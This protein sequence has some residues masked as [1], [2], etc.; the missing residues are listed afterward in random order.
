VRLLQV[1]RDGRDAALRG[2]FADHTAAPGW[3]HEDSAPGMSFLESG[4]CV[5][6]ILDDDGRIAGECG[7][8]STPG[9]DGAVEIGYGLAPAS[10]GHGLGTS[11]VGALL[12]WLDR[13]ADVRAVDAEVHLGNVASWR[14]LERLGFVSTGVDDH[15]Y[16]RYRRPAMGHLAQPAPDISLL[17]A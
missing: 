10:R 12:G 6:L 1:D 2:E 7:T 11:A 17:R 14:V 9:P 16:R 3:P 13:C 4:G 15:G 8:K 5:F